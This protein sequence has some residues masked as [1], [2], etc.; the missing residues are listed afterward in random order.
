MAVVADSSPLVYLAALS[1]F[2]FLRDLFGSVIIQLAVHREV[3]EQGHGFAA[4][5]EVQANLGGWLHVKA[6][7]DTQHAAELM[8]NQHLD[9][10]E[11]EAIV[12][13][14][15]LTA[16]RLLMDDQAGVVNARLLGIVVTRTPVIYIEAK[17]RGWIP[18]VKDRFDALRKAGF[19]L[20]DSDY[21][22][23]LAK[24]NEPSR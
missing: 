19:W 15:E 9:A 12:L 6:I 16:D 1:A 24:T 21:Q 3:V 8:S 4:K 11:S 23:I 2:H 14:Q 17:L 20:K 7:Q 22:A 5:Q 18:S 10:G 13:A